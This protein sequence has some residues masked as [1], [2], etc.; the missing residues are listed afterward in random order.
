MNLPPTFPTSRLRTV[1]WVLLAWPLPAL[2]AG[3]LGWQGIWGSGSALV[4]YLI[5]LPVAGGVLH[6]PS[7]AL[8][9]A[10]VLLLPRASPMAAGHMRS[11]LVGMVVAGVLWLLN[12]TDIL[13]ALRDGAPLPHRLWQDKPVG[14]FLASDGLMALLLFNQRSALTLGPTWRPGLLTILLAV[15]PSALPVAMSW[16]HS[17]HTPPFYIGQSRYGEAKGD[18]TTMVF[19]RLPLTDPDFRAKALAWAQ[20]PAHM[21]DPRWLTDTE[22]VAVMFTNRQEVA[23]Q[24]LT[25]Q[26]QLTLCLY[27]DG[28]PPLW[29]E[30]SG[31]CFGP[32]ES[33]GDRVQAAMAQRPHHEP[34]KLRH[35]HALVE[36]CSTLPPVSARPPPVD[37]SPDVALT[38]TRM[39][40]SVGL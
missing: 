9:T 32:H 28:T 6:I 16:P 15:A 17:A 3:A 12:L 30:G 14:L 22:D 21:R 7:F 11:A 2:V 8:A 20:A 29:L 38:R 40:A 36:V 23:D 25:A 34:P 18:E 27:E 10:L 5:P 4:D 13:Q 37:G 19:T 26:A 24:F 1:L 35:R 31:D 33:F 39:C